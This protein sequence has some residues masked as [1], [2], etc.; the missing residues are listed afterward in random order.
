MH[1]Q[2]IKILNNQI[3]ELKEKVKNVEEL[4]ED[5]FLLFTKMQVNETLVPNA[6]IDNGEETIIAYQDWTYEKFIDKFEEEFDIK[7]FKMRYSSETFP[8]PIEFIYEGEVYA[9]LHPYDKTF[10]LVSPLSEQLLWERWYNKNIEKCDWDI[11]NQ[12][13]E[14]RKRD[15]FVDAEDTLSDTMKVAIGK[16]K[17]EKEAEKKMNEA[18]ENAERCSQELEGIQREMDNLEA[19]QIDKWHVVRK[20]ST[21]VA[22]HLG[23][24]TVDQRSKNGFDL[25]REVDEYYNNRLKEVSALEAKAEV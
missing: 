5:P 24:F 16:R 3:K 11:E 1:E 22:D 10:E 12:L 23:V 21:R 20:I 15:P 13:E 18:Q 17:R 25:K 6:L 7:P 8:S 4:N 14:I 19:M 2:V 9:Q